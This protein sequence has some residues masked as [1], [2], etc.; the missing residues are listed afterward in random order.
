MF[1]PRVLSLC[2]F[3]NE[4]RVDVLV[5]G[6]KPFDRGAGTNIGEQV[7]GPSKSKVEGDMTLSN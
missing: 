6:F 1:N 7:E 2:V 5:R 4:H 3:S